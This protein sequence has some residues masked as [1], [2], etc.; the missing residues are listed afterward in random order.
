MSLLF[1]TAD[2][3]YPVESPMFEI[4]TGVL[5]CVISVTLLFAV[6]WVIGF[7]SPGSESAE[8][9]RRQTPRRRR[10]IPPKSR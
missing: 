2:L 7:F 10:S 8:H 9:P 6:A 1:Y 5:F 4:W 3:A